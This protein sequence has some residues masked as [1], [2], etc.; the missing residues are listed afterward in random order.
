MKN[1]LLAILFVVIIAAMIIQGCGLWGKIA[2]LRE[3]AGENKAVQEQVA[4]S[5]N[6]SDI[7]ETK[8]D[9]NVTNAANAA[10]TDNSVDNAEDVKEPATEEKDIFVPDAI[11]VKNKDFLTAKAG[12]VRYDDFAVEIPAEWEGLVYIKGTPEGMSF[13]QKS[14]YDSEEGSGFVFGFYRADNCVATFAGEEMLK[15]TP[16]HMYYL[17]SPTDVPYAFDVEGIPEEYSMLQNSRDDMCKSLVIDSE[18]VYSAKDYI[19][20]MAEFKEIDRS[21]A[22][23]FDRN[24]LNT[25]IR[26]FYA[27]HGDRFKEDYYA[28]R[29][30]STCVWYEPTKDSVSKA[31]MNDV[32]KKNLA[33]LEEILKDYEAEHP[34][35]VEI[36]CGQETSVVLDERVGEVKVNYYVDGDYQKGFTG[37][38]IIDGDKYTLKDFGIRLENPRDDFFYITD[39]ASYD[40]YKEIAIVDAGNDD[41]RITY[42]FTMNSGHIICMNG[43]PGC[44]IA[45]PGSGAYDGF[46]ID[47]VVVSC[48]RAYAIYNEP[49]MVSYWIDRDSHKLK[50]NDS[51]GIIY[52]INGGS[53]SHIL[54]KDI[55]V[56]KNLYSEDPDN[57]FIVKAGTEIFF[58]GSDNGYILEIKTKDGETGYYTFTDEVRENVSDYFE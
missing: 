31:D 39:I 5:D 45:V 13:F 27:R 7:E 49:I 58:I 11:E 25:A 20:P 46:S 24:E 55:S 9:S 47:G 18:E 52:Q 23:M 22:E 17:N 51:E 15:Y 44:P 36:P 35:P 4:E 38:L 34:Y 8:N 32:E 28:E 2:K 37:H 16:E 40:G 19:L 57:E 1:K 6:R 53:G 30:F 41:N 43:I 48:D 29:H 54:K 50:N 10:N 14:S 56:R 42:F 26:E 12:M 21:L 3:K 33:T